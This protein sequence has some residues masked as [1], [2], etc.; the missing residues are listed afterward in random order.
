MGCSVNDHGGSS[1]KHENQFDFP[2]PMGEIVQAAASGAAQDISVI[3]IRR[4]VG[5]S[6]CYMVFS[7]GCFEMK[8]IR[9]LAGF[10][11][12]SLN[13]GRVESVF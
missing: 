8:W 13:V 5:F 12:N 9:V 4:H 10:S 3:L 1:L 11:R 7:N 2:V 6:L